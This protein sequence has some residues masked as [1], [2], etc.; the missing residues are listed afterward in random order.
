MM[1]HSD[2]FLSVRP[3]TL[4]NDNS[5]KA[6]N[7]ICPSFGKKFALVGWGGGGGGERKL[8]LW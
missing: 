1:S 8:K 7:A 3:L 4:S 2:Q 5:S 6:L